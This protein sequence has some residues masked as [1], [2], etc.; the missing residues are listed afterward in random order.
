S[1]ASLIAAI[2]SSDP[3]PISAVHPLTPPAF[4]RMV[5]TCMA[6][7]PDD[8]WQ[9]A[10]DVMLQLKWIAEAGS[11]AGV[12][13]PAVA[14]RKTRE[15][16]AWMLTALL[17]LFTLALAFGAFHFYKIANSARPIRS[18]IVAPE[19]SDL[20][21]IRRRSGSLT[22]SPDGRI[23]TFVAPDSSGKNVLWI[24]QLDS[25]SA[26]IL[27]GTEDAG[28]PFWSPDSHF[29]GFFAGGKLKK[30]DVSGGPAL[31][32]CDALD[33]RGGTWN[34]EGMIVF[35]PTFREAIYRV[36]AV[37]GTPV[38]ITKIDEA[39]QETT[40]RYP[41]FLPDGKHFLYLVGSHSS[42]LKSENNA[43]YVAS[44][45]GKENKLILNARSN[46]VY[47]NGYLLFVR[48]KVLLAQRFATGRLEL[49]G[50]PT[51][52]AEQVSYEAGFFR[53]VFSA[54]TNGALTYQSSSVE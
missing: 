50:D 36:P 53:G 37:G 25:I 2:L 11:Q 9:T 40:H 29:I 35:T 28:F 32:I 1:Q 6:K 54:S 20:N 21:L 19:N 44:I 7:D 14:R 51:P 39:R 22:I 33:G 3:P 15:R 5:K 41:Y 16:L 30:I 49:E 12:P 24:R 34:Q 43:I 10:H 52:L 47:A 42:G 26:K 27:P 46:P 17:S 31:N 8:R 18:F 13:A 23:L 38:A 48:E 45:D 4:E